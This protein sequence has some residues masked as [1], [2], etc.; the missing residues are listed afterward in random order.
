LPSN[1]SMLL[2]ELGNKKVKIF[3]LTWIVYTKWCWN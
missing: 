1:A 2:Q 3:F